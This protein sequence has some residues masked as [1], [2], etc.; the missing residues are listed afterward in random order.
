MQILSWNIGDNGWF[1][2]HNRFNSFMIMHY[3][4]QLKLNHSLERILTLSRTRQVDTIQ[5][6]YQLHQKVMLSWLQSL[7]T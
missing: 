6:H 1:E 7:L 3:L 2:W 4:N 5:I